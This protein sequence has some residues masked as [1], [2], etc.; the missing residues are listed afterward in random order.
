[1]LPFG[2]GRPVGALNKWLNNRFGNASDHE[3]V[4]RVGNRSWMGLSILPGFFQNVADGMKFLVK[5]K[6]STSAGGKNAHIGCTWL[7]PLSQWKLSAVVRQNGCTWH[8]ASF[9]EEF[10]AIHSCRQF[11]Q[12]LAA[13]AILTTTNR[14]TGATHPAT[15]CNY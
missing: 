2:L 14:A 11:L 8:F 6:L 12:R 5:E 3:T 10:S 4:D 15:A 9:S 7:S 1:M 13:G